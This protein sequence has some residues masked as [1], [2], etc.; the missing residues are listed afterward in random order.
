MLEKI[1]KILKESEDK[2]INLQETEKISDE[3]IEVLKNK[4]LV[5]YPA[6]INGQLL[7]KT[8]LEYG[9]NIEFFV[10]KAY[11]DI[12]NIAGIN[13]F[14]PDKLKEINEN[15]TVLIT[16]NQKITFEFFDEIVQKM[17]PATDTVNGRITN[18]LLRTNLCIKKL[19]KNEQ[20]DLL[21]CEDCGFPANNCPVL[22][23]YLRK[24]N[25][26][27]E[28]ENDSRSE[29]FDWFG[30]IVS[31]ICT[32]KCKN[33]CEHVPHQKDKGF[34][35]VEKIIRD[36]K[37]IADSSKFLNFVE[38]IGGE[39][40]LHPHIEDLLE[41]LLKLENIGYIKSFTNATVVP[42]DRACEI[43]KNPRF[44]LNVSN[45]EKV[46]QG[47]LLEN[48][49]T[50][51]EKLAKYGIKYLHTTNYEWLDFA[52][53]DLHK[54][55]LDTIKQGFKEC[56]ISICHRVYKGKLYICPHQYAGIQLGKLKELP[57]ETVDIH[58]MDN[59][60]LAQ[61][62]EAF[63]S[64]DFPDACRYCKL[65]YDAKPIIAGEQLC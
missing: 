1:N 62:L 58:S 52:S 25:N 2:G 53:F 27:K 21:N 16:A 18:Q 15:Y 22:M 31:Q 34:E 40:F 47:K 48:I 10:D 13:V 59:I 51:K 7:Q 6:G 64:I 32:L 55:D 44:V 38:L 54:T 28:I 23:A 45:Y 42:S 50:T 49:F 11:E 9:I 43:M 30:Y 56:F 24:N 63:E 36:V 3:I 8:L 39:P 41:E 4:K 20:F 35:P 60:E 29:K 5:I 26:Y 19:N 17:K 57:I 12:K 37:K 14:S 65:P 33:C 61:A 46:A